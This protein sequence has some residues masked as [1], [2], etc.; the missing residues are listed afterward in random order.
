MMRQLIVCADDFGRE[1]GINEAVEAAHRGGI[2]STASLMVTAT[3]AADA[4]E[5]ARRLPELKIGLHL[6]LVDDDNQIGEALRYF[7]LP[8]ARRRLASEIRAQFEA[9]Q[10][11]GL[12]LDHVN[13]HKHMHVHPTVA[14]LVVEIGRDFGM[15]AVRLPDEPA[16][17]LNA[18][19]PG[20]THRAPAWQPAVA[21]LRRRLERAG[22]AKN[23][24]LFG[25]AWTGG[26]VEER[27]LA[28]LSHL[29]PGVSELY[30]HPATGN[31]ELAALL[32]PRA[33]ERIA[34]LGIAL[35]GYADLAPGR[36]AP[37][38]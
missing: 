17:V 19:A 3:A 22:L 8:G 34:E 29:P 35:I 12:V 18:A 15:Q 10:Q 5:R 1:L 11:T 31:A 36:A 14:R 7:F 2:L 13:A 25:I 27:V 30:C 24:H 38:G 26:M 9:F 21:A 37:A 23:D 32:S 6:A 33:R 4:V 16:A 20:E 28:L